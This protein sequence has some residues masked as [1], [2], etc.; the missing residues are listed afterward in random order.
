M[1]SITRPNTAA[2]GYVMKNYQ[3]SIL[4]PSRKCD[5]THVTQATATCD[6]DNT[7]QQVTILFQNLPTYRQWQ[8]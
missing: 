1:A 5:I 8:N 7:W 2:G 4:R 6:Y 3:E